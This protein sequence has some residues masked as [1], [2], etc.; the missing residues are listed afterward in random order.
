M[1][2]LHRPDGVRDFYGIVAPIDPRLPGGGGYLIRGLTNTPR[3]AR[4]PA[5]RAT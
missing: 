3:S 4:C 1:A 2:E 5:A